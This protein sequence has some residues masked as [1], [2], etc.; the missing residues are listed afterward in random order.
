MAKFEYPRHVMAGTSKKDN[1]R[2]TNL[3]VD[4]KVQGTLAR[5]VIFHFIMFIFVGA[6]VG[7][8]LQFLSDPFKPLRTHMD[9]FWSQSG[10]YVIAMLCM[11]PVFIKDTVALTHR[12]AGPIVRLRGHIRSIS[13]GEDVPPL[14][15]R[16]GDFFSDVPDMFNNM[17][18]VV[19]RND[20]D[21]LDQLLER[22]AQVVGAEDTAEMDQVAI[23]S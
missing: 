16:D 1:K 21:N 9:T 6:A 3:Y 17:M 10:P 7:L 19:T 4:K 15:F 18:D 12:M 14:K 5:R 22:A 8:F 23:S 2:G 20:R 11:L 13:D